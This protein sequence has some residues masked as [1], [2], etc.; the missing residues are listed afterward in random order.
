V[1]SPIYTTP[2]FKSGR[3]WEGKALG[4]YNLSAIFT[5]RTG[6]PFSIYDTTNSLNAGAG[7]GIPR[8]IP[9]SAISS[10]HTGTPVS[11]GAGTNNFTVLTLPGGNFTAL[12]PTLGISDFGPFPADM[13]SRNAFRG[14]GAWNLDLAVSKT[15]TLTERF[16]LEF[17]AEGF[18]LLNHHNYYVNAL[19]LD[20]NNFGVDNAGNPVPIVVSALKG[21]LGTNNV[22]GVN[23]DE[24]R[25]GQFALRLSF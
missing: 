1:V 6:T 14:P 12:N 3:G 7:Y 23:H 17:R 4:G 21:G 24:R 15:F 25:F 2:W 10:L 20:A 5:A 9:T 16:K 8:Y 22:S 11:G 13:T 19:N 18:D